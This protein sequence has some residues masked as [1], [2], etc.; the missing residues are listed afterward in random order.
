[1]FYQCSDQEGQGCL[2]TQIRSLLVCSDVEWR[3]ET[4][5]SWSSYLGDISVCNP[6]SPDLPLYS[7]GFLILTY[8][9]RVEQNRTLD[10]GRWRV[11]LH[12]LHSVSSSLFIYIHTLHTVCKHSLATFW[13]TF[14]V[15]FTC[16]VT[17]D[18]YMTKTLSVSLYHR[19][20]YPS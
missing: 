7:S 8:S 10:L 19:Q 9:C 13:W 2:S 17:D 15:T 6:R 18:L 1:M 4:I 12:S 16:K 14:C 11:L 3:Q 5:T 20:K